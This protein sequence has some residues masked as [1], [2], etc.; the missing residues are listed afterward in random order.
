[1]K[2]ID[3]GNLGGVERSGRE[4]KVGVTPGLSEDLYFRI[5]AAES[6]SRRV[7]ERKIT[8]NKSIAG[9]TGPVPIGQAL[10]F[11][12]CVSK[13]HQ[14]PARIFGRVRSPGSVVQV[15]LDL[16]PSGVAVFR[17]AFD[18]ALLIL[19]GRV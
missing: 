5:D 19:L 4:G 18:Q 8:V 3:L 1:M 15:N 2:R 6:P 14:L 7:R 13:L 9:R 11:Q 16:A 17:Q 12:Q 10:P